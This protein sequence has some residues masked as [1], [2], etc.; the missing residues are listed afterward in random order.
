MGSMLEPLN[1]TI[2][3]WDTTSIHLTTEN[4]AHG[5]ITALRSVSGLSGLRKSAVQNETDECL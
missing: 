5:R 2:A 1:Y 3:L 4:E